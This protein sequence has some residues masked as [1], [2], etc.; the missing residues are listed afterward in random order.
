[1]KIAVIAIFLLIVLET[2][3]AGKTQACGEAVSGVATTT[4]TTR[5]AW[6]K[7][8]GKTDD[9]GETVSRVAVTAQSTRAT[10]LST[11][12]T[13]QST[14]ATT[15]STRTTTQSARATTKKRRGPSCPA[16][17]EF[18]L[19]S[20]C[21]DRCGTVGRIVCPYSLLYGCHCSEGLV[22]RQSDNKCIPKDQCNKE[23]EGRRKIGKRGH[24]RN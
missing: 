12:A 4:L 11:R 15:L 20:I 18:R 24:R 21:G 8:R 6:K 9:R 17:E 23:K 19:G 7:R 22:R 2:A 14:R 10:T 16:G 3:F 13:T 1:M 5:A